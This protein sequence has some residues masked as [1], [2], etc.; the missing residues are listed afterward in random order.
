ML[1]SRT[2]RRFLEGV[3]HDAVAVLEAEKGK[4]ARYCFTYRGNP[5]LWGVC[6]T[7]W[8]EAVKKAGLIDFRFHDLRHTWASWHRQSG[9]LGLTWCTGNMLV[10]AKLRVANDA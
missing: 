5:I 3:N 10:W 9:S 2:F 8:L 1:R 7:G 6:N 4:H